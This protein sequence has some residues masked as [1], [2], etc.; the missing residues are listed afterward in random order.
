MIGKYTIDAFCYQQWV[1]TRKILKE[2]NPLP[3]PVDGMCYAFGQNGVSLQDLMLHSFP[4][5]AIDVTSSV[6]V[7]PPIDPYC[8]YMEG[9]TSI[10]LR[11][12]QRGHPHKK[13]DCTLTKVGRVWRASVTEGEFQLYRNYCSPCICLSEC[14]ILYEMRKF[15]HCSYY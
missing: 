7:I 4:A 11:Q 3:F 1:T 12:R 8:R 13:S 2:W 14:V 5:V 6:I 10:Q 15:K 9:Y